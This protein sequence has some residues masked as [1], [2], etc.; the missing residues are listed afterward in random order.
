M[1]RILFPL[2]KWT[3]LSHRSVVIGQ[4]A[5]SGRFFYAPLHCSPLCSFK[6]KPQGF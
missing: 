5:L 6:N 3:R 2:K 4:V 1:L